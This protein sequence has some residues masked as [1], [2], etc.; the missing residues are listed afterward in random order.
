MQKLVVGGLGVLTIIAVYAIL[1]LTPTIAVLGAV[2]CIAYVLFGF[3]EPDE[4]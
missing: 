1:G 3:T 4:A 2:A